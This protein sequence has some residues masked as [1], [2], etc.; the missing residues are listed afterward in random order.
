MVVK[1]KSANSKIWLQAHFKDQYVVQAKK[2]NYVLVLG[3]NLMKYKKI[4]KILYSC[5]TVVDLGAAPGSWSQYVSTKIG[6]KGRIIACD[7][8]PMHPLLG[9]N[10]VQGDFCN[11]EV[12]NTIKSVVGN[13]KVQVILSDIAPNISGLPAV[14][15]PKSIYLVERALQMCQDILI[16]GG[17]F[18]VKVFHG[19]GFDDLMLKILSLFNQVKIFKPYASSSSSREIYLVAK[20]R[21]I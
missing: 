10:F 19:E 13:K 5:I 4:N 1:K 18:I 7:I 14:D 21:K 11:N 15:I 9:V 17:S 16:P 8:L 6:S 3:L 12:F 20:E 2:I